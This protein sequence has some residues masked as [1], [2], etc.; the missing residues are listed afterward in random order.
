[1]SDETIRRGHQAKQTLEALDEILTVTR[2]NLLS[3]WEKTPPTE[4]QLREAIYY[5]IRALARVRSALEAAINSGR[6]EEASAEL[7]KQG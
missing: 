4:P 5:D 6:L 3:V 7:M 1:M 2:T